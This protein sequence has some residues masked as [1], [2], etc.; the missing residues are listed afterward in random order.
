M[1]KGQYEQLEKYLSKVD[2]YL[3]YMPVTEKTDILSELKSTFFE[4][5]KNGQ[6]EESIIAELG[7]PKEL[8]MSY[9]GESI[10]KK[11]GFSFKRFM[12]VIGFYS[13]ASMAWISII[14][15]LAVLSVSFF[16][17]SAV[18]VLAGVMGLLKGIIHISIID[19][20][21]FMFFI[22]ELKG[23][24]AFLVGLILAIIFIGLGVL[25]WKGTVY[26]IKLLQAQGWKLKHEE[27]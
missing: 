9:M 23:I 21:K 26:I 15:T 22:Y 12:M 27:A 24:P 6:S 20:L 16:F 10:I 11:R 3:K 18:S 7:T 1:K 25:C 2:Y 13:I 17:S 8:A 4:R 14:P 5:I 19:N